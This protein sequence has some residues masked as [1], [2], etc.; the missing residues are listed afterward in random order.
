MKF[1]SFFAPKKLLHHQNLVPNYAG[2]PAMLILYIL[3][4]INGRVALLQIYHRLF[5]LLLSLD[6]LSTYLEKLLLNDTIIDT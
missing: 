1:N 5:D 6:E 4:Q 2:V 3:R